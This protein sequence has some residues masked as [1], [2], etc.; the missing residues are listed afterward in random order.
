V[1]SVRAVLERYARRAASDQPEEGLRAI[2]GLRRELERVEAVQAERALETGASWSDIAEALGVT[3]Q[4]AH[5]KLADVVNPAEPPTDPE[6]PAKI[7]VTSDARQAVGFARDEAASLGALCVGT[8][9]LLLGILRCRESTAAQALATLGVS[10]EAARGTIQPTL[11]GLSAEDGP[12]PRNGSDGR[13][14]IS[15]HA[16]EALE[17]S[18]REAV[19]RDEGY[20]GVEHLLLALVRDPRNGAARTLDDLEIPPARIKREL[21]RQL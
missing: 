3:K 14:E 4:A 5:K 15:E 11:V 19:E 7:L 2:A 20:I 18:L 8:E 16:R 21:E 17:Q 1:S 9:H 10:L 6:R 13:P 12:F